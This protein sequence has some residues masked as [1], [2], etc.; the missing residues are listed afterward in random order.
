MIL[1][2]GLE[3]VLEARTANVLA[4]DAGAGCGASSDL[5]VNEAL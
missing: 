4:R 1:G 3:G 2:H 5:L